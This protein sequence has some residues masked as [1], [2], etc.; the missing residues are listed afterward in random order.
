MKKSNYRGADCLCT[1][2]GGARH[3]DLGYLPKARDCGANILPLEKQV[4]RD[5]AERHEAA[6]DSSKKR[7]PS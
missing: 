5:A 2:T 1:E 3:A 4:R 7:T 6:P